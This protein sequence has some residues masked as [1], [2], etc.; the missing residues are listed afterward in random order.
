MATGVIESLAQAA[1]DRPG[2]RERLAND[3]HRGRPFEWTCYTRGPAG[4]DCGSSCA[5]PRPFRSPANSTAPQS[6]RYGL[7]LVAVAA[8]VVI[9]AYGGIAIKSASVPGIISAFYRLWI[10]IPLLWLITAMLPAERR[11]FDPGWALA[12]LV[13]GTVFAAHQLLYFTA[14]KLTSVANVAI[15]GALQPTLVLLVAGRLFGERVTGAALGWSAVAVVGTAMVVLGAVGAPTWSPMGDLLASLNLFAFTAYFLWSKR[16]RARIGTWVYVVGMT[17]V[18]GVIMLGAC[19]VSAQDLASPRGP[20]WLIFAF[21]AV[22]PGTIGHM[23]TNWAH[24]HVSAFVSSMLLLAVPVLASLAAVVH[25][26]EHLS[27]LQIAGGTIALGAIAVI[28]GSLRAEVGEELAE[29]AA[30]TDAP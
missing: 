27:G 7:G 25:L 18:A 30:E 5:P 28:V 1:H 15:I 23:L 10:A 17:T 11:R 13:G 21:L 29:S 26:G 20:D 6:D 12:C 2:R 14:L 22:L 8:T 3:A 19:L 24:A 16:I 9:W 4:R